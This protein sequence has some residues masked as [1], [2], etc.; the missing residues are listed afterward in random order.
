[1]AFLEKALFTKRSKIPGAGLGL[2][3]KIKI[4]KGACIV[5]YKGRL[6]RWTEIKHED[7]HNGYILR[8]NRSWAIDARPYKKAFGRFANDARGMQRNDELKNNAEYLI[9]G[10][11]CFI[12]ATKE[13]LPKSEVLVSYGSE[14]W[15]LAKSIAKFSQ[16]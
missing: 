15:K 7:G 6:V 1:M 14:Y 9:E 5:E 13:I 16:K 11:Q 10:H 12:Y 8:V 2:F 3:T 4:P